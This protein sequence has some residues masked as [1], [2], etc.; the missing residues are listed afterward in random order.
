M[1]RS[2]IA[3]LFRAMPALLVGV[4][5]VLPL[6]AYDLIRGPDGARITWDDGTVPLIIKMPN[7]PFLDDGSTYATSVQ[8]AASAWGAHLARLQFTAQV[9]APG[10]A[11]SANGLNEIAFDS[12]LYSNEPGSEAF[13]EHV[14]AVTISYRSTQPRADGSY[15]RTQAD[16]LFNTAYAWNSYRGSLS[17]PVDIRRVAVHELGHVLGLAHPDQAGQTVVALMNSIA[18]DVAA[19]QQDDIDGAQLLYGKPG[20]FA[21]PRHDAFID[22]VPLVLL[23]GNSVVVNSTTVGASHEPGEPT[24]VSGLGA[25]ASAWWR[26]T[27]PATGTATVSTEGSHFDTV[28][29][30]YSGTSV[31]ALTQLASNDDASAA[32]RTSAL[33]INVVSGRVYHFAVDGHNGEWGVVRLALSLV[34]NPS[35]PP[36]PQFTVRPRTEAVMVGGAATFT[37][38]A[39]GSAPLAFQWSRNGQPIP[40]ATG[41]SLALANVSLND[42]GYYEVAVSNASGV[43]RSYFHLHVHEPGLALGG[44]GNNSVGQVE[45]PAG[46]FPVVAM[47]GGAG[48]TIALKPDGTVA[49]WGGS[50]L[51]AAAPPAGLT[52]VVAIAAQGATAMALQRDGTVV[53]WGSGS[54]GAPAGLTDVIAIATGGGH[55]LAVKSDGSVVAWGQNPWGQTSVPAA[56]R[57]VVAVAAGQDHSAALRGDGG[58]STWGQN[59]NYESILPPPELSRVVALASGTHHLVA[60][61]AD[62]DVVAWGMNYSGQTAVPIAAKPAAAVSAGDSHSMALAADGSLRLWG[63]NF[64]G[65]LNPPSWFT[66]ARAAVGAGGGTLVLVSPVAPLITS[67]PANRV[68]HLGESLVLDVAAVGVPTPA[69]R[70]RRNGVELQD[71]ARV[72]GASTRSL[73]VASVGAA[74]AG[75]YDVVVTNVAGTK[76]SRGIEVGISLPP[77]FTTRPTSRSVN[78]GSSL[79]LT[80]AATGATAFEWRR[81]GQVLPAAGATLS[82][83]NVSLAERGRYEVTA[84]NSAGTSRSV[85]YVHVGVPSRIAVWGSNTHGQQSAPTGTLDLSGVDA[86]TDHTLAVRGDGTVLAWGRNEF[87]QTT[88]PEDL[89]SVVQVSAGGSHSLALTAAGRVV[90][91]GNNH[92]GQASV[93]LNLTD[94]VW[95]AAGGAHSVALKSD[96]SIVA[97]GGNEQGQSTVPAGSRFYRYVD[98]GPTHTVALTDNAAIAWGSNSHGQSTLD[99]AGVYATIAAGDNFTVWSTPLGTVLSKGV[100]LSI[101]ANLANVDAVAAGSGHGLALTR[102]GTVVAFGANGAGQA[103]V[104][105]AVGNVH[106]IAAGGSHSVALTRPLPPT[107]YL[108]PTSQGVLAG[109]TVMLAVGASGATSYRWMRNGVDLVDGPGISGSASAS[110]TVRGIDASTAGSYSVRASNEFGEVLSNA[111]TVSVVD[112]FVTNRAAVVSADGKQ[113]TL[114]VSASGAG[115]FSYQWFRGSSGDTAV[116]VSGA[117]AS[118]VTVPYREQLDSY[119]VRVSSGT[120]AADSRTLVAGSWKLVDPTFG[121]AEMFATAYGNGRHVIVG[122]RAGYSDNGVDW[123]AASLPGDMVLRSVFHDG[124]RFVAAGRGGVVV[125]SGD[126][127]TWTQLRPSDGPESYDVLLA[128]ARGN[129]TTVFVG[130]DNK[131]LAS[132]DGVDW[133]W[134][135]VLVGVEHARLLSIA[136]GAGRFVAVGNTQAGPP[137]IYTSVDGI[138]WTKGAFSLVSSNPSYAF[139]T[140]LQVRFIGGSFVAFGTSQYSGAP[141]YVLTSADGLN[142]AAPVFTNTPVSVESL[143][144]G[145]GRFL[146]ADFRTSVDGINWQAPASPYFSRVSGLG[147]GNGM[148]LAVKTPYFEP[149]ASVA[150]SADGLAWETRVGFGAA[151]LAVHGGGQFIT[152]KQERRANSADGINWTSAP[153]PLR[154]ITGAAYGDGRFIVWGEANSS[155]ALYTSTDG[156]NWTLRLPSVVER[157]FLQMLHVNGAWYARNGVS[158]YRSPDALEWTP[159]YSDLN[160]GLQNF[161]YANGRFIA[162]GGGGHV[163]VS[164]DGINWTK[165]T[166]PTSRHFY[167][168]AG[169]GGMFV[170]IDSVSTI[171]SSTDGLQWTQRSLPAGTLTTD[172]YIAALSY[173]QG[174]FHALYGPDWVVSL[175]GVTWQV[176]TNT[177]EEKWSGQLALFSAAG[178]AWATVGAQWLRSPGVGLPELLSSPGNAQISSGSTATLTVAASGTNLTYQWF[179]GSTGDFSQPIAG[180]T[181]AAFTTPS[182][183]QT[184]RY[185]VRISND[186]GSINSGTVT[187][188]IGAPPTIT[189]QPADVDTRHGEAAHL[190]VAVSGA[191]P[192]SYQWYRGAAGDVSAPITD[193]TGGGYF[194]PT[195]VGTVERYWV[196][197]SNPFGS[198]DSRAA[199]VTPW[200]ERLP[201]KGDEANTFFVNGRY[202]TP[203]LW[204]SDGIEWQVLSRSDTGV[205]ELAFADGLYVGR[206]SASFYTSIDGA[207][208]TLA[209]GTSFGRGLAY[210]A[211]RFVAGGTTGSVFVSTNGTSWSTQ[212]LGTQVGITS[213]LHDGTRFIAVGGQMIS[214]TATAAVMLSADGLAWTNLVLPSNSTSLT[215]VVQA[216]SRY[217]AFTDT[218]GLVFFS[219]NGT[220]WAQVPGLPELRFKSAIALHGRYILGTDGSQHVVSTDGEQWTTRANPPGVGLRALF[221]RDGLAVAIGEN[222][223]HVSVDGDNWHLRAGAHSGG[224]AL[225]FGGGRFLLSGSGRAQFTSE[226]AARWTRMPTGVSGQTINAFTYGNGRYLAIDGSGSGVYWSSTDTQTWQSRTIPQFSGELLNIQWV[227]GQFFA[228]GRS[229]QFAT[230]ADGLSWTLRSVGEPEYLSSVAFGNGRYVIGTAWKAFASAD[231]V[232]WTPVSVWAGRVLFGKGLFVAAM[233]GK[234]STS[235]DGL[236]WTER[237]SS[238]SNGSTYD[239]AFDGTR[240][241]VVGISRLLL[242]TDGT[243]WTAGPAVSASRIIAGNGMFVAGFTHTPIPSKP[244]APQATVQ[245]L[246]RSITA[247]NAV[248]FYV[249]SDD[250]TARYQWR[251]AGEDIPGADSPLFRL[252]QALATTAGIYDVV[253]TNAAG[254]ATSLPVTLAV[255]PLPQTLS[256]AALPDIDFTSASVPLLASASSGL[257]VTF[258]VIEGPAVVEGGALQLT[259]AGFVRVR[260]VQDGAGLY[261]PVWSERSFNVNSN[262]MSWRTVAFRAQSGNDTI[263]GVHADPDGDGMSNLLEYAL[264][265]DPLAT[266]ERSDAQIEARDE[267]WTFSYRRPT[268][269]TDIVYAVEISS[270]LQEWSEE[271]VTHEWVA[272][273]G[274]RATWR[275]RHPRSSGPLFFRLKVTV[276]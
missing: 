251:R 269:R 31:N 243:T 75:T 209:M 44:W 103:T 148:F 74:D 84:T 116:P 104:P 37:A 171:W 254:R 86:G 21:P 11:G 268:D 130:A 204:S 237:Y 90:A 20:G 58:V 126:G 157:S 271:G 98:A 95:I 29:A 156:L 89:S 10:P 135:P 17:S 60:R 162:V 248:A 176:Q 108:Q 234:I 175:D 127:R 186:A 152:F 168:V 227:N 145:G 231:L 199:A 94:V 256:F 200:R 120:L 218:P 221:C 105:A 87:G 24:H 71:G 132:T 253:V 165:G 274:D 43:A 72:S 117:T 198:V 106:A 194:T 197:V 206:R 163:I 62:D 146:S 229:G 80:A 140:L 78:A 26:W 6:R 233:S 47:A 177:F 41:G 7:T 123:H 190:S 143:A 225:G 111:A 188:S 19:V 119:W 189:T 28:L 166:L 12:R 133:S 88:V 76:Q 5:F 13:G 208:W 264:G 92:A 257:P 214:G 118:S 96:G 100:A 158:I 150:T 53:V 3:Q 239:V 249:E 167:R 170:A 260:A 70:W 33:S 219:E 155:P 210:G 195:H 139:S 38:T 39:T 34:P 25:G 180:A 173:S 174:M 30:A 184:G 85:F 101:P 217:F 59:I 178:S 236:T 213:V 54:L 267:V 14:L 63:H 66:T 56:L 151:G 48:F 185:W 222:A 144:F 79:T 276:P 192:L 52:N 15:R 202:F 35:A 169:G 27:A 137:R 159:V 224:G 122:A 18:G 211:G 16:I 207:T 203:N 128:V 1:P 241:A 181:S 153:F 32:T 270:D 50:Q 65:Q 9:T 258:T 147:Y 265:T 97:W 240:F 141:A 242:S 261:A 107:L 67:E 193:A 172:R 64:Y 149:Y 232:N 220:E 142:W 36:P 252:P 212:P 8:A 216:G 205:N 4:F 138:N 230:S 93:P 196:R 183:T 238:E 61:R 22:A 179:L 113:V 226:N 121:A 83:T 263:A 23:Q 250:E 201:V 110:L 109:E 245:P 161:T 191:A 154:Y 182:L 114:A 275:A 125:A 272:T 160:L 134:R 57:D 40:G 129:G 228:L 102:H 124:T 68:L 46:L 91:W 82:L 247:G 73:R 187:V 115:P 77:E 45:S 112:F 215:R 131:V 136:F 223:I 51:G 99:P 235:P 262:R 273:E 49:G 259:G 2:K 55:C 244:V 164:E 42:R 69:F 81:N 255:T 246:G 266:D